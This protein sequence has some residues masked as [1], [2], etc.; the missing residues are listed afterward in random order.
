MK[1]KG[2]REESLREAMEAS[3]KRKA[4]AAERR[5]KRGPSKKKKPPTENDLMK[6]EIAKELG[7]EQRI[8][9]EGFGALTARETGKIG[10][11]MTARK[12]KE[13]KGLPEQGKGQSEEK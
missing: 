6:M 10:G 7:F 13:K 5:K 8:L 1:E 3:V 11:I 2:I 4:E 9:E 12:K